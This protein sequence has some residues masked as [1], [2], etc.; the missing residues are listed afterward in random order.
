MIEDLVMEFDETPPD[1]GDGLA[2]LS[3]LGPAIDDALVPIMAGLIAAT[4]WM[5]A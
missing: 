1:T 2:K 5:S 3:A 4:G